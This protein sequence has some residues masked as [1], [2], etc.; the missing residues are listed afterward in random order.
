MKVLFIFPNID[1]G[2]YKPV[3]LT[4]VMTSSQ[5][6]GHEIRLFDTSF[7]EPYDFTSESDYRGGSAA[8]EEILN[9]APVNLNGYNLHKEH[10]SVSE[11]LTEQLRDFAPD[12]IGISALSLEWPLCI[13]LMKTVKEY[14]PSILT[15]LGGVHAYA[16]PEGSI[17]EESLD[18]LCIG[19]GEEAFPEL[20]Q[21]IAAG[22]DYQDTAGFW[23]KR[24]GRTF[25]NSI[26]QVVDNLDE[27]PYMNYD[28]YDDRLMYR[29]YDG[30]VYRSADYTLT[31]GCPYKCTYCLYE[32][33]NST[34][35]GNTKLRSYSVDRAVA[36]LKYLKDR[37]NLDFIRFQDATFL[38]IS[39]KYLKELATRYAAEI[40]LPFV[41]DAS[42]QTVT[43][44]KARALAEMGCVSVSVGVET[45][46]EK[47]RFE[48][49]KKPVKNE[50]IHRAFEYLNGYSLR[51]VSFLLMGFPLETEE[52]YWDS[53][54]LVRKARVNAPNLGFVYP[55]KGS[56][57]SE[58]AIEMGL[59]N[60]DSEDAVSYDRL[61]PAISNP[62]IS[63][64]KYRGLLRT[65]PL[66]VKF[67]EKYWDEIKKAINYDADGQ[68]VYNKFKKIYQ[69]ENL[70]TGFL[71]E[72]YSIS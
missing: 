15:V 18:I 72:Q 64:A 28:L 6:A 12:V 9:F 67:P 2:G 43:K 59:F 16:D 31:R 48:V 35:E 51:T 56:Q 47:M 30:K 1:C 8:G 33:M 37:Y 34:G 7:I 24:N 63:D 25:K 69:N 68:E 41:I 20:L 21:N 22:G 4:T 5:Q 52:M 70:Y 32:K 14:D 44:E 19:E 3:G 57:L 71:P 42:P 65:F 11:A 66:F 46:N 55:F 40:G 26:G 62:N 58:T 45:G 38:N 61:V 27:L 50:V 10:T 13:H 17:A 49:C 53:V 39:E 23:I 60:P 36:E 29:I 54:N